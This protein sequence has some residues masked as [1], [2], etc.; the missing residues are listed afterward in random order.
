MKLLSTYFSLLSIVILF[1]SLTSKNPKKTIQNHLETNYAIIPTSAFLYYGKTIQVNRYLIGKTEVTNYEYQEFLTDLKTK[2]EFEKLAIAQIDSTNWNSP[3]GFN[4]KYVDYYHSHPA[5]RN[6]PVVNVTREGAELYCEWVSEKYA[7]E[8]NGSIQLK[9]RLP[10]H[11]EWVRA[12]NSEQYANYSW[13]HNKLMNKEGQV[14][15]NY[16]RIGAESL[17][18]DSLGHFVVTQESI[19]ASYSH[20]AEFNYQD[21]TAPSKSYWPNEFDIYNLNGNVA[22][23]IGDSMIIA[24][25]SWKDPGYD[26]RNESYQPYSNSATN[27]GFRIVASIDDSAN[28]LILNWKSKKLKTV[29]N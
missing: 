3:A 4:Q 11:T 18:R 23:L 29:K 5:Y 28:D 12:T 19:T 16:L 8:S 1:I 15:A 10:K 22:E 14:K 17:T 26:I 27:I 9:F 24:G 13:N 21:V 25:G 7:N 6:Y 2:G 20:V